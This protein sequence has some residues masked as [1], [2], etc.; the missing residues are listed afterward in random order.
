MKRN[1]ILFFIL[2]T[3]GNL[4]LVIFPAMAAGSIRK[5]VE[6]GFLLGVVSYGTLGLTVAWLIP[7]YPLALTAIVIVSG[8]VFSLICSGFTTFI[9]LKLDRKA[10]GS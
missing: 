5:A 10:A 7:G 2:I 6:H 9:G 3:L 8:G 4:I 1:V